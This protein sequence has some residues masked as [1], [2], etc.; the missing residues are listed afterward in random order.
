MHA[1]HVRADTTA[2]LREVTAPCGTVQGREETGVAVFRG[3]PYAQAPVGD[4]R[5]APP[6]P[7]PPQERIDATRF[8]AVSLQDI[9]PLPEALPGTEHNYYAADVR[10]DED[11]LSLNVW[12]ADPTG[13][14]PVYVYIH[15]GAFLC[16]SGT[17]PWIS[18]ANLARKH[19]VVVVTINY[20]LGILGGLWLG[21]YEP[22]SSNLGVQDAIQALRWVRENIAAF[23]GDPARVT[24]GGESAGGMATLALLSAPD[25]HG[26]FARAVVESA[27]VAAFVPLDEARRA[28]AAV[29]E[30]LHI[31]P[32]APDVLD[33]LRAVS[34]F[35]IAAVQR[36]FGVRVRTF[37][38]VTDD[39]ILPSDPLAAIAGGAAR[40]VD[41]LIGSN[42][43]EDRLFTITGWGSEPRS[44]DDTV[45]DLLH[46]P[47]ARAAAGRLYAE[48]QA[49]GVGSDAI[50]FAITA[51]HDWA[52]PVR[53][54]V[55]AHSAS[56]G[57][58]YH[59]QF[60]W[61][62]T[63]VGGA[64]GAAHLVELPFFFDNLDAPGV[65]ALLGREAIDDPATVALGHDLGATLA[66]FVRTGN[67]AAGAVGDWRP[68]TAADRATMVLDRRSEV[69]V[70]HLAERLDF[71]AD[72]RDLSTRPLAWLGAGE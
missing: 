17:G 21:D 2:P 34:V 67:L 41:L 42:R 71:W 29:L 12:S 57:R 3:I 37:P 1:V 18:G 50:A 24:V 11:C 10:A 45:A 31:D 28:T 14:A 30:R 6:Q 63:A 38:L 66:Q 39:R 13:S 48:V 15:G 70:D 8:G 65:P 72:S 55:D 5:F 49:A 60:A 46:D 68:Y 23:G 40:S 51:D 54:L 20:R 44:I 27:H 62:S 47:D 52:E 16:G 19:G 53:R 32:A 56:G 58:T 25:A 7:L 35:R 64:V 59:Y 69:V 9:D 61:A 22:Q 36:E 4:L 26:L 33:Q 43:E